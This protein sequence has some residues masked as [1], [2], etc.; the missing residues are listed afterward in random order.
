VRVFRNYF[1]KK[2]TFFGR[3]GELFN[4]VL[5][6]TQIKIWLLWSIPAIGRKNYLFV[7]SV[8]G[9]KRAAIHYSLVSSAK[10]NGVEPLAWLTDVFG[11]LPH[12]RGG[13][14]FTQCES[15]E[16]VISSE[17]DYLLPDHW[18]I[19]NPP[20]KW[21]IDTIRRQERTKKDV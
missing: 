3:V 14:A 7:A 12:H 16:P 5:A 19:E 4:T 13:D 9:G 6:K 21:T 11:H 1:R 2:W 8:N 17:L 15:G 10:S 20:H 18:L